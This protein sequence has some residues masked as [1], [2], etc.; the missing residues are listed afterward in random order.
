[1]NDHAADQK[2]ID[3]KEVLEV[4]FWCEELNLRAEELTEI[5][6]EVGPSVFDV[7]LFLAKRLLLT[8][9]QAY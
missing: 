7:R 3:V 5:V 9:P 6:S 2:L 1:M 8:W 4:N